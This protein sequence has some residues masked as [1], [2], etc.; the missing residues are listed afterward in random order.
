MVIPSKAILL[1]SKG[2]FL[3]LGTQSS[4][5]STL[6][7]AMFGLQFAV[8]HGRTTKGAF[9]QLIPVN[10]GQLSYE[11]ILVIDTEGLRAP[12]LG[13]HNYMLCDHD[14]QGTEARTLHLVRLTFR[15]S[16]CQLL[17]VLNIF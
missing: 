4:G 9:M 14:L 3:L 11:Y 8:G 10:D 7:N 5:K 6:L 2:T 12:E 15:N 1:E 17:I 16:V 13:E